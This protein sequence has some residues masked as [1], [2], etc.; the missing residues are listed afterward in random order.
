MPSTGIINSI[1][2][3]LLNPVHRNELCKQGEACLSSSKGN[4]C[5]RACAPGTELD[6]KT[7]ECGAKKKIPPSSNTST[8]NKNKDEEVE[9][10]GNGDV[11]LEEVVPVSEK[12]KK[13][14]KDKVEV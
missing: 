1:S 13:K 14:K 12:K 6:D 2:T 8:S 4:R 7:M 11:S 5:V 9:S 3:G 10:N